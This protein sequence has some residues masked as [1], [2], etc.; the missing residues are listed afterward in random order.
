MTIGEFLKETETV[1]E[2]AGI[3]DSALEAQILTSHVLSCR[4]SYLFAHKDEDIDDKLLLALDTLIKDRC[5]RRPLQ[6]VIGKTKFCGIDIAVDERVLIPRPETEELVEEAIRLLAGK[7]KPGVLDLCTGSGCIAL[8]M[9][10]KRPDALITATEY[11]SE[12]FMLAKANAR[13]YDNIELLS[14]DLFEALKDPKEQFDAILTN[15]PYIPNGLIKALQ[16]EIKDFEPA[17][18]LDGGKDGLE[19][20]KRI[21]KDAPGYIKSGGF[22][23]METGHDQAEKVLELLKAEGSLKVEYLNDIYGKKRILRAIKTF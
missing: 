3:E 19:L 2:R 13:P 22:M 21:I 23:L 4:R 14:G 16:P 5:R 12:A 15:P 7:N 8:S 6:Y 18:A 11:S 17:M 20:I 1:L 9:A 10:A